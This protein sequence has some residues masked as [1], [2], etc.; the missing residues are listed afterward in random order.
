MN[1][2]KRITSMLLIGGVA[3]AGGLLLLWATVHGP[4]VSPDSIVYIETARSLLQ[5]DGFYYHG[6]PMTHYPP[7]YPLLLAAAGLLQPDVVQAARLLQ[8]LFYAANVILVGLCIYA[9]TGGSVLALSAG[10]FLFGAS[11]VMVDIHSMAWSEPPFIFFALG[12]VIFLTM[13]LEK[14]SPA[15][16]AGAS[17]FLAMAMATRYV[18]VTL[19]LTGLVWLFLSRSR[20]TGKRIRDMAV[21]GVVSCVPLTIWLIRNSLVAGM[22]TNRDPTFN[23]APLSWLK[24]LVHIIHDFWFPL[25]IPGEFKFFF[26]FLTGV[27][28]LYAMVVVFKDRLAGPLG[29]GCVWYFQAI[30][31]TFCFVY[32][33]FLVVTVSFVDAAI[34]A[35]A[36][37]L[38]PMFALFLPAGISIVWRVAEIKKQSWIVW[39]F[40]LFLVPSMAI[41][42]Q[43]SWTLSAAMH[44]S[45]RDF[46]ALQW[47]NSETMSM[48]RAQFDDRPVYSNA[49]DVM[50]FLFGKQAQPVPRHWNPMTRLS[51]P[52]LPEELAALCDDLI[53]DGAIVVYFDQ[54]SSFRVYMITPEDIEARCELRLK[55]RLADGAIYGFRKQAE[56][57]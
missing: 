23:P 3:L 34:S 21:L 51:N 10:V 19:L 44:D 40:V 12:A 30:T 35:D 54:V 45:G 20:P 56:D 41:N 47:K 28:L 48:V 18:G 15:K 29:L 16:L 24:K 1:R 17:V 38:A 46:T 31:I 5:G 11:T 37:M 6:K 43:R 32:V 4:G 27:I 55:L 50:A 36:R 26:L 53:Q 49:P 7:G 33:G 13:H 25:D 39:T 8:V 9:L 57:R 42:A 2:A 52:D 22:A 14:P